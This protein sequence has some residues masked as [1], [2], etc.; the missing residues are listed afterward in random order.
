MIGTTWVFKTKRDSENQILDYNARLCA[1]GFSQ[2]L[3]VDFSK[4]F[5][6]T[7]KLHSLRTLISRSSS[8]NLSFEQLDIKSSFFNALLEEDVYLSILQGLDR[9]NK[10]ILKLKKE[11]YGL[12]Q[13]PLEWCQRLSTWL[14]RIGFK[15]SRVDPC[16]FYQVGSNPIRLLLHVDNIGVF[17]KNLEE[18]K[19]CIE[20][21][22]STKILGKADL[23]LGIKI[24][25]HPNTITL[26]QSHYIDS[27]LDL[28]GMTNCKSVATPLVPNLCYEVRDFSMIIY[29]REGRYPSL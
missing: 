21:E 27:L 1:Q 9:D 10:T 24:F 13:A 14:K 18:F 25:Y 6:P 11:I 8:K 7:G 20:S 29:G 16:V 2:T 26:S 4:T 17:G 5:A 19:I 15:I 23:I 28:Y 12:N 3:G 22:F